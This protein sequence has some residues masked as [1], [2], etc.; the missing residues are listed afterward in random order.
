M[1][2]GEWGKHIF[3]FGPLV[4]YLCVFFVFPLAGVLIQSVF[5]PELTSEHYV[6]L[7]KYPVYARVIWNTLEISFGVA[8]VCVV[9]GY[10]VAYYLNFSKSNWGKILFVGILL[11]IWI[12]VLVRT[13]AWMVI[14]G[15]F[16]VVNDL[17]Q[18][19][20]WIEEPFRL[21][22]NRIGVNV[23]LIY[24]LLPFAILPML[25]VMHGIDR[26]LLRAADS[27]GA[28]PWKTFRYVFFPLSLP[29]VGAG[30]LLIFMICLGVFVT[31]VL[32]GG[33]KDTM[34]AMSIQTQLDVINNWGFASALS[35]ALLIIVLILFSLYMHFFGVETLLGDSKT[36]RRCLGD[37]MTTKRGLLL[38]VRK[39]LRNKK[40]A[41]T[42]EDIVWRFQNCMDKIQAVI[43]LFFPKILLR[44]RWGRIGLV[45]VCMLVFIF[46][47][48]PILIVIPLS[49]SNDLYMCFPPQ[50][51]GQELFARYFSAE[52][53]MRPTWNSF[54]VA[55][56]VMVLST[57]LG[58]LASLSLVRGKYRG[59]QFLYVFFLSPMIIPIIISAVSHYFFFAKLR[60]IGTI[61]ALVLSHTVLAI[62]FVIIVM[63]STLQ[64]FDARLEKASMSLGAGGFR[65]FFHVTLPMIRP[66]ILTALLFSFIT[67]F[68]EFI[69][70]LFLCGVNAV[71][72]PKQMWDGIRDEFNPII[73][74]V[75]AMLIFLTIILILSVTALRRRQARLYVQ[76]RE[77]I[78]VSDRMSSS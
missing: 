61:S 59:K 44:I 64:G 60:M 58:T 23:G 29:G 37:K 36:S 22:Y 17:L 32:M 40:L 56:Q 28:T 10:P 20:G 24:N 67:S 16:G 3:L 51:W 1:L 21:I 71:T 6:A 33:P 18:S 65:T 9:F 12:S 38:W 74:A 47:I 13:Y 62:P 8:L 52:A 26:T 43:I 57:L 66:G 35:V 5:D 7:V 55:I 34:I 39:V 68:D 25:S 15:R 78:S 42:T 54:L 53:W 41:F 19:L 75:A 46:M 73:S 4:A 30:F 70:S 50:K 69:T 14:L 77:A 31:P 45:V 63:T 72:L 76:S 11:P 27:L 49:F 2:R 48:M